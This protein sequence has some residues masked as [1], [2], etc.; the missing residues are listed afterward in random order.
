MAERARWVSLLLVAVLAG[1]VAGCGEEGAQEGAELTVY[2]SAPGQRLCA[3]AR[4]EAQGKRTAGEHTLR[5]VCL[6]T[7]SKDGGTLARVGGNARRATEDS[8]TVAF[9]GEPDRETR[10]QSQPI[11]ASAE[12]G[13][14]GELSGR[15]AIKA[16][17]AAIDEGD[18]G[19]PRAAVYDAIEG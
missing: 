4:A 16:V 8:T 14:L 11:L 5:V 17:I 2:V 12:I 10:K 1:A 6:A 15:E 7:G 19:D 18:S 13:Q 3:E 9:L